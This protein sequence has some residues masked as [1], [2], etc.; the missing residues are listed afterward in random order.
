MAPPRHRHICERSLTV[1]G[2]PG[3]DMDWAIVCSR[4][5]VDTWGCGGN[6]GPKEDWED[7]IRISTAV[8]F[9]KN[10]LSRKSVNENGLDP[11]L[12][13]HP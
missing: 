7:H 13:S 3:R 11:D 5:S 12:D 10:K 8:P 2:L 4:I 6:P 1:P 9:L